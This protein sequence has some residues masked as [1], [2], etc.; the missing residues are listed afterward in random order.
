MNNRPGNVALVLA[1]LPIAG[2]FS[3]FLCSLF[4]L[5]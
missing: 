3:E 4:G 2:V 1:M 5:G